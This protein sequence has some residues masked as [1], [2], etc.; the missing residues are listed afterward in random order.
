MATSLEIK[1]IIDR[2]DGQ[3]VTQEDLDIVIDG[4]IE[5]LEDHGYGMFSVWDIVDEDGK[6]IL[7][8]RYPTAQKGE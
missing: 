7:K 3:S 1:G 2:D 4:L 6:S 5:W 8:G